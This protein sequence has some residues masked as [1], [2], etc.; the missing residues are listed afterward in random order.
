MS[1]R[2]QILAVDDTPANLQIL[3]EVLGAEGYQLRVATSAH[4]AL[5]SLSAATPDLV[6]LDV[7]MPGGSGLDLCRR[8]KADAGWRDLP[9]IFLS[10]AGEAED[11]VAGFEAGGADYVTKPFR[12]A[13]LLARV[14]AHLELKRSREAQA[15]LIQELKDVLDQVKLLSGLVPICGHC[16]KIRDDEGFWQ[17]ME[18]YVESHSEAQFSHGICPECVAVHYPEVAGEGPQ[19]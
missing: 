16:H 11:I 10:A 5:A 12:S 9:V 18:S 8:L 2:P 6:L 7:H 19:A 13:E 3:S 14:R 4:A 17:R 15:R 1:D